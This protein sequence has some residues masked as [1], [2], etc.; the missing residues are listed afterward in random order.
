M[1]LFKDILKAVCAAPINLYFDITPIGRVYERVNYA[2][3]Q[4]GWMP[5]SIGHGVR[6]S[7]SMICTVSLA[8][9]EVPKIFIILVPGIYLIR[10][11]QTYV[12]HSQ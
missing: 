12:G 10:K 8:F 1:R 2:S 4:M 7:F 6:T 5:N 11:A 9:Y 3:D